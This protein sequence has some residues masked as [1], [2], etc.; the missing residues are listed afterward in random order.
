MHGAARV[1]ME[2]RSMPRHDELRVADTRS[3]RRAAFGRTVAAF[4]LF[5]A[6][7]GTVPFGGAVPGALAAVSSD[8]NAI[9]D[10]AARVASPTFCIPCQSRGS[11]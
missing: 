8:T 6:L 1:L 4:G 11:V 5:L 10:G 9:S 7:T 2:T 3:G